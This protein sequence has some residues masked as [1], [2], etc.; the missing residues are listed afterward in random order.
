MLR[1]P[2][3]A[4]VGKIEAP[5]GGYGWII[6]VSAFFLN[7]LLDGVGF[8][9]ALFLHDYRVYFNTTTANISLANSLMWGGVILTVQFRYTK[10]YYYMFV[11]GAELCS[12]DVSHVCMF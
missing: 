4:P 7:F 6:C 8:S 9:F 2:F 1:L 11:G 10:F 3:H 12:Y 5:D